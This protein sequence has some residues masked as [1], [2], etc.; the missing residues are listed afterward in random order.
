MDVP[1]IKLNIALDGVTSTGRTTSPV[2]LSRLG[3]RLS[4]EVTVT[5]L[6]RLLPER[7]WLLIWMGMT[8]D[9]PASSSCGQVPAVV[10]P[11]PGWTSV[12]MRV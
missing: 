4:L 7:F 6:V 10:Q 2:M 8:P 11:Q 9:L 5:I 12:I 3:E 1:V